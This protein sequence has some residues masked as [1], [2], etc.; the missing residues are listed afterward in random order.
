MRCAFLV[1]VNVAAVPAALVGEV[2]DLIVEAR[3]FVFAEDDFEAKLSHEHFQRYCAEHL[4]SQ[5]EANVSVQAKGILTEACAAETDLWDRREQQRDQE[6]NV[7]GAALSLLRSAAERSASFLQVAATQGHSGLRGALRGVNA[8]AA[9]QR[10]VCAADLSQLAKLRVAVEKKVNQTAVAAEEVAVQ[11]DTSHGNVSM[12][13]TGA[14]R[15]IARIKAWEQSYTAQE[16][17]FSAEEQTHAAAARAVAE[18]LEM[19]QSYYA[20]RPL[21]ILDFDTELRPQHSWPADL[22]ARWP[23]APTR[24]RPYSFHRALGSRIVTALQTLARVM[25][26][27]VTSS[28]KASAAV[29]E[30]GQRVRGFRASAAHETREKLQKLRDSIREADS[31]R[32]LLQDRLHTEQEQLETVMKKLA[33][34]QAI[35]RKVTGVLAKPDVTVS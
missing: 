35:C 34:L 27:E 14:R 1:I 2:E 32:V 26:A 17:Q 6:L 33:E 24:P 5:G 15:M 7:L 8:T 23:D 9:E 31:A 20:Q 25:N 21:D 11:L 29:G 12:I 16:Q 19:L 22:E 30:G 18:A 4:K 28:H 13:K 10:A 3:D